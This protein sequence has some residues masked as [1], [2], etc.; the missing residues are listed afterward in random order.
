MSSDRSMAGRGRERQT[1]KQCKLGGKLVLS[2]RKSHELSI[3][4]KIGDLE[5]PWTALLRRG[6]CCPSLLATWDWAISEII[7]QC[8]CDLHFTVQRPS[9]DVYRFQLCGL[10]CVVWI[11]CEKICPNNFL[12]NTS[13]YK[14]MRSS[15]SYPRTTSSSY[16]A[17]INL[18]RKRSLDIFLI[19]SC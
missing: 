12:A 5:W 7:S 14:D 19:C 3:G 8:V 9:D 11:N 1:W 13:A 4:T 2:T 10:C 18:T 17:A 16:P 15:L 6:G